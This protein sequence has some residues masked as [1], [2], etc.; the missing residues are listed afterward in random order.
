MAT[1]TTGRKHMRDRL[2]RTVESL[3]PTGIFPIGVLFGLNFVDEFD[4]VAFRA[5][6][7][8]IQR[9]FDLD[10]PQIVLIATLAAALPTLLGVPI[11]YL[12]DRYNRVW[13][14]VVAALVWSGG[15]VLTGLTPLLFWL[16]VA[17]FVSGIGR[18][19]NEPIHPSLLSDYYRPATL[20]RIFAIHRLANPTGSIVAGAA[21][22]LVVSVFGNWRPTFVV[23]ALPT[24]VLVLLATRLREPERGATLETRI[25]EP[26]IP[27]GEAFRRL[28]AVRSLRRTW[29]AAFL[30]GCGD[31]SFGSFLSL[32]Y[33]E[34]YRVGPAGRGWIQSLYSVGN[35][36]GLFV[37]ARFAGKAFRE[38]R[39]ELLILIAAL[40]VIW[41]GAGIFLM[42][43]TPVMILSLVVVFVVAIGASGYL[44]PYLTVVAMITPPR[45]RSQAYGYALLFFALGGIVLSQVAATV[46]D[47]HGLRIGLI[48]LSFFVASG[49]AVGLTVRKFIAHDIEQATTIE[50]AQ[51][52]AEA[53]EAML[54]CR[55]VEVAYDQVQ[56]LFGVDFDAKQGEIVTL[57]GTNGAGKSTLL[58]AIS[59]LVDPIGGAIFFEGRDITHADPGTTASLGIVQIPGGRGIFPN[60]SVA[61][62]LRASGWMYRDDP[63]YRKAA[64]DRALEFFPVLRERYEIAAG[65]LS[66]GEQQMLSLAQAFIARPKLMLIDELSLGLA[67][68]IVDDLLD[69]VRTMNRNG[70]TIVLVE[71]SVNTALE[72]AHRAVF[73]EK[74]EVRFSGP[75]QELLERPDILRAVFLKS[76]QEGDGRVTKSKSRKEQLKP[77]AMEI[78]D[79]APVLET[80]SVS[81]HYGGINA[82]EDVDLILY[83]G[84]ILGL[85][86]PNGAGKTTFFD[87]ISGFAPIDSGRIFLRSVDATGWPASSRARAGLGRSFQD[88]RLWHSLTVHEALAV[89]L[90]RHVEIPFA[91]PA[92]FGLPAVADSEEQVRLRVEEI[93]ELLSLQAFRDKFVGELSTGSRRIVEI[94]AMLAQKPSILL[95]DEPSSGLAQKETEGLGPLLRRVR[96]YM[97]CSMLVI[98]H[99]M[100]LI[101]SLADRMIAFDQGRVI[102]QGLPDEVIRDRLVIESYLG[103]MAEQLAAPAAGRATKARNK[104]KTK[105]ASTKPKTKRASK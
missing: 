102:A 40:F 36:V 75:A 32:F 53:G 30:F 73:M 92:M 10:L 31:I 91:F 6:T 88:S 97:T 27:F 44:P 78:S 54:L 57:L 50:K 59:G 47:D 101:T 56:V 77:E 9:A 34:I 74:G 14:A 60:L 89:A 43:V 81:K 13:I 12:G 16:V 79:R 84:E 28:R 38:Q 69:I 35:M 1:T 65:N 58:K 86:G 99:H 61:D 26:P 55:G 29:L 85:I 15:S 96:D 90:E 33:S 8:E 11:G 71:Q 104:P 20:P 62:N 51:T 37:G 7:P 18:L 24:I 67:P 21:A 68:T 52:A 39:R 41:F 45:L 83:E 94:A 2:R 63:E 105:R 80:R 4:R 95:L 25:D 70:T 87:L 76:A 66:G 19:V 48:L 72:V 23:L 103:S 64:T 22:A 93:V 98:E 82:V 49:G 100:P 3:Q 17:R 46:G 42:A 5:F